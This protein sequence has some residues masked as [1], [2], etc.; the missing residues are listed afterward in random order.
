MGALNEIQL[1]ADCTR[2]LLPVLRQAEQEGIADIER[3]GTVGVNV[4]RSVQLQRIVIVVGMLSVFEAVLKD[5]LELREIVPELRD[6][7]ISRDKTDLAEKYEELRLAIN[8][9]K[10]GSGR[11]HEILWAKKEKLSFHIKEEGH[12]FFGEGDLTDGHALILVDDDFIIQCANLIEEINRVV[13]DLGDM[14]DER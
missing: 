7:L 4:L 5:E 14:N 13:F 8:V 6:Y 12:W 2:T 1:L 10:H 3:L 11:S 9:L